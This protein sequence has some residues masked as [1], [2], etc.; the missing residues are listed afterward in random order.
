M[1]LVH[2]FSLK[3]G[4]SVAFIGAGGKTSA[5]FALAKELTPPVVLTTTTHLGAWQAALADSHYILNTRQ[6]IPDLDNPRTGTVLLTG[7]PGE[8]ERLGGLSDGLLAHV[9]AHCLENSLSLL[10]EADGARQRALKAPADHEPVIPDWVDQVVVMAGLGG[11]G[12]PLT[13]A[14]VH[15][16]QI[17]SALSGLP[18]GKQIDEDA[19]L[20]VLTSPQ[21][22]LKGIPEDARR[23]LFLNQAEGDIL[24][25]KARGMSHSLVGVY[26]R[27][28]I[29]S[30]QNPGQEGPIFSASS[31]VAGVL[32]AAGG[33][34]RLGRPKQLLDWKGRTFVETVAQAGL[35][36]GLAP[37]IVVTG[38][39]H[40]AVEAALA[41]LPVV[42]VYNPDWAGGQAS[43]MHK[44]L[45]ALP[46]DCDRVMFLLSDQPQV[47]PLLIRSLV[48]R[49]DTY[50]KPIT[51]PLVNGQRGNPVLFDRLTFPAL[52]EIEGDRG[53]RAVFKLFDVDYVPWVDDRIMLDVDRE[54]DEE[55]LREAY[56][57]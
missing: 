55:R 13:E 5:M 36:A 38:A 17:F 15:R 41:G 27:V 33:S 7:P 9:R 47:S 42:C 20:A 46:E 45:M 1:K 18:E 26:D 37:L 25:A 12:K 3:G 4:E 24:P 44:G 50:R 34:E 54:G 53:G 22:G 31:P 49:H 30:I 29:G 8:D 35:A 28:L 56:G 51:V 43:S 40:Q 6:D 23:L 21:G 57:L 11:I 32:L 16:P 48:E 14:F 52:R 19:L 2:A 10:I 39:H